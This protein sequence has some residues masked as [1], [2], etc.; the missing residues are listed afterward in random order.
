[1]TFRR[2][3]DYI[4]MDRWGDPAYRAYDLQRG[5]GPTRTAKA[6]KA[7]GYS[8]IEPGLALPA[9][10]N[11]L[12]EHGVYCEDLV[13]TLCEWYVW[14]RLTDGVI[15]KWPLRRPQTAPDALSL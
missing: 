1:M 4:N 15:P 2:L 7:V 6:L 9:L 10:H 12:K 8:Y 14:Q 11:D 13:R 3:I 5:L